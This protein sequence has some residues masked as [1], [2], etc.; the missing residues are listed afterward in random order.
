[1]VAPDPPDRCRGPPGSA[2]GIGRSRNG[3]YVACSASCCASGTRRDDHDQT[4]PSTLSH[5]PSSLPVMRIGMQG[6]VGDTGRPIGRTLPVRSLRSVNI[7]RR[8]RRSP[9]RGSLVAVL[10]FMNATLATGKGGMTVWLPS[11]GM[12]QECACP[13]WIAASVTDLLRAPSSG[14]PP[15][16]YVHTPN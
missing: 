13:G 5:I 12:S 15:P 7:G 1:M 4:H 14:R 10:D 16:E 6:K 2:P 9:G 8:A 11:A 3:A